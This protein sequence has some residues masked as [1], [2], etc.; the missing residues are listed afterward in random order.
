MYAKHLDSVN[1]RCGQYYNGLILLPLFPNDGH[2]D[3]FYPYLSY[4]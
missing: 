3:H 2:F 1:N 4:F